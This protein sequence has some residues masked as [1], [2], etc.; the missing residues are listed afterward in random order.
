VDAAAMVAELQQR[1]VGG[2]VG[3][4]YQIAGDSV[5]ITVQSPAEGRLDLLI[6]AGRRIHITRGERKASKTPPQFPTMLRAHLSG[7]RIAAVE[8]YDFDRVVQI[9]VERSSGK[10]LLV[11]ELFPKGNVVLLDEDMKIILPLRPMAFRGRKLVAGEEYVYHYGQQ[12]PR[13]VSLEYLTNMLTTSDADLVRTIVRGLNMGGVYGEE[14]CLRAGLEKNRPAATLDSVEVE[15]V[16]GALKEV[17]GGREGL[18]QIVYQDGQ[19]LDVIPYPLQV[20]QEL[21]ARPYQRF[22]EAL[23]AFFVAE[24]PAPKKTALDRRLEVQQ[25]AIQEFEALERERALLGE[26]VYQNYGEIDAVLRVIAGAREKGFS[27]Q[28]IWDR[29]SESDLPVAQA[30]WSLDYRGEFKLQVDGRELELNA[31]LTVPQNAQRYYDH[32]KEA[33]RKLAG[34]VAAYETTLQLKDKK[35]EPRRSKGPVLRRRK[36]RWFERFRWFKSSDDF[37]VIGGRDV[38]SNEE[39]YAKYLEKRDL[40]LHTDAPGAPLTVIKT[41][42]QEVPETTIQEA[43]QFAVSYSSIW[44]GGLAEGDC[45]LV[46]GDQVTKTPEPG[47]FLRKGAFVIRGERRYFRD[48]PVGVAVGIAGDLLIGGPISAVEER[49]DPMVIVEPGEFNADDLAKRIYRLFAEKYED[50][51]V[52]KAIAPTDLIVSFLPPGG[53][54]LQE[55]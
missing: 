53:S 30:I 4:A 11:V 23:D 14:V 48:V 21:E 32:S 1:L 17:F 8:Q 22:S 55:G 12:D 27:Y 36:P 42:G 2:F 45:Y 37:L 46:K 35:V 15:R 10:R 44:K 26:M 34:A 52:I 25:R 9:T 49:A 51:R 40:A 28:E 38:D 6:E 39:I 41:E 54:R 16:Y 19:P 31:G 18:P 29:I 5:W 50:K 3:K 43:A 33:G 20:Y 13:S 24:E 47:E 7:G